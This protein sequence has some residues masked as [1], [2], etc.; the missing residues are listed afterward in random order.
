MTEGTSV[1]VGKA[2]DKGHR[3]MCSKTVADCAEALIGAY[4]VGGGLSAAIS[5]MRWLGIDLKF[6]TTLVKEAKLVA[7]RWCYLA[8]VNELE[9]LE[10]KLNY[11]FSIKGLL[12][13][14]IT[15]PSRQDLGLDY[16]YQV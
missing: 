13:E 10:S 4:Y 16:C 11:R 5:L 9:M 15:H 12:L 6:E 3:W 14:A 2:C 8:L 7:S 1:V